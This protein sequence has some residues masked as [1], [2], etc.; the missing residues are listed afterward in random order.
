MLHLVLRYTF[1]IK[2]K[3]KIWFKCDINIEKS[4]FLQWDLV[5][6]FIN[7]KGGFELP[8]KAFGV[9]DRLLKVNSKTI[10]QIRSIMLNDQPFCAST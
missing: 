2:I 6:L 8:Q 1:A 3:I 7:G 10:E 9:E 5:A 4:T